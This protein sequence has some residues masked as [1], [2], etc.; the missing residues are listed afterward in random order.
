MQ[1]FEGLAANQA[2]QTGEV[3]CV[4]L[5]HGTYQS[6]GVT[7]CVSYGTGEIIVSDLD[8]IYKVIPAARH[9][10][11]YSDGKETISIEQLNQLRKEFDEFLDEEG[12]FAFSGN[13]EV[14]IEYVKVKNK[15]RSYSPVYEEAAEKLQKVE[16]ITLVG[17]LEDTGSPFIETP[18]ISGKTSFGTSGVYK[19]NL[20]AIAKD[21]WEI[22]SQKYTDFKFT[23]P[24]H[25]N[26]EYAQIDGKYVLTNNPSSF[27]KNTSVFCIKTTLEE[28]KSEENRVRGVIRKAV[29]PFVLP[30]GL[31]ESLRSDL[32][33]ELQVL[34]K[35]L[36]EVEV[37]V[38]SFKDF[39]KAMKKVLAM[40]EMLSGGE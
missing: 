35:C 33:K 29:Y 16:G 18:F 17:S 4:R 31:S 2:V 25:S 27:I 8:D 34:Y 15:F 11:G 23:R 36:G 21:E 32:Y 9:V 30:Q 10:V 40:S 22:L 3:Y 19:V 24:T 20:S 39:E 28:A 37:K 12:D 26:V 6:G 14:E 5:S 7:Y 38:K 1:I 13:T